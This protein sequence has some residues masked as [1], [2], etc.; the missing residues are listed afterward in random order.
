MVACENGKERSVR[1]LHV[2]MG[3]EGSNQGGKSSSCMRSDGWF[4]IFVFGSEM[5][6]A[7]A[8]ESA[9]S[10]AALQAE[11]SGSLDRGLAG[12]CWQLAGGALAPSSGTVKVYKVPSAWVP[13]EC[14][15][16]GALGATDCNLSNTTS[17]KLKCK[18]HVAY[19]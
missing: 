3:N 4:S 1:C 5:Q 6:T 11:H 13:K 19:L 12:S 14:N 2:K 18:P 15:Y 10:F 16:L 9:P 7:Y 8:S 17:G